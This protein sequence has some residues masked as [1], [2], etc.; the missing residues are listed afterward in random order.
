MPVL[1]PAEPWRKSGRLE[2]E[3]LFKLIDRKGS[4]SCWR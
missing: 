4:E 3:E 2:I 1:Q